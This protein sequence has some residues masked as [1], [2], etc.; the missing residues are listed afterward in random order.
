MLNS[1]NQL[2]MFK[3]NSKL[4]KIVLSFYGKCIFNFINQVCG[5][6]FL[7]LNM[8]KLHHFASLSTYAYVLVLISSLYF[9]K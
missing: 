1:I 3:E 6:G 8:V 7:Y 4:L 2:L 9:S 5:K